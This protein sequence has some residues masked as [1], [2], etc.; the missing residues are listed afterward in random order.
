MTKAEFISMIETFPDNAE[1]KTWDPDTKKFEPVT[2]CV[3]GY[4]GEG[5]YYEVELYTDE[6]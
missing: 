4:D 3:H 1:I 5:A 2:G 6:S